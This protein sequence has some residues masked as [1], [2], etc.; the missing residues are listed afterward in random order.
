MLTMELPISFYL[1]LFLGL[2]FFHLSLLSPFPPLI[3]SSSFS[4]ISA[5][6]P[7]DEQVRHSHYSAIGRRDVQLGSIGRKIRGR[8]EASTPYRLPVHPILVA[9]VPA[10]L[11]IPLRWILT[12][13]PPRQTDYLDISNFSDSFLE[14][15]SRNFFCY[16]TE[17]TNYGIVHRAFPLVSHSILELYVCFLMLNSLNKT[18]ILL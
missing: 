10:T 1:S 4:F 15:D 6:E 16:V 5:L 18:R 9:A 13:R 11:P 3:S 2:R 8:C 7:R 12:W 14:S 17:V